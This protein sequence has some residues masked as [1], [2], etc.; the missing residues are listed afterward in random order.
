MLYQIHLSQDLRR[1]YMCV[2]SLVHLQS[3][4]RLCLAFAYNVPPVGPVLLGL[5]SADK[6]SLRYPRSENA[7][8]I[9]HMWMGEGSG[10]RRQERDRRRRE[11]SFSK[12]GSEEEYVAFLCYSE[13]G[14]TPG[15][16]QLKVSL[17]EAG[18]ALIL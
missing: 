8:L 9:P 15:L 7:K 14:S 17:K 4:Q 2:G 13:P 5:L 3:P 12:E 11:R 10:G 6:H 16:T 1:D 18:R